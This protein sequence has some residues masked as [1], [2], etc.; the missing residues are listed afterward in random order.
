MAISESWLKPGKTTRLIEIPYYKLVRN[1]RDNKGADGVAFYVHFSLRYRVM[2]KSE[3][4]KAYILRPEFLFLEI[5][6]DNFKILCG[7][8]YNPPKCGYWSKVEEALF[9]CS[10]CQNLTLLFGDLNIN[11]DSTTTPRRML[12]E[13]LFV[14]N[15]EPLPFA[16]TFHRGNVHN[17]IDYICVSDV[18]KVS[19]FRQALYPSI[20]EHDVL[21]AE[22]AY[23]ISTS[24]PAPITRRDFRNFDKNSFI[25]DLNSIDWGH[26][27]SI[28]HVDEKVEFFTNSIR[29]LYD[30]HAPFR[31]Y[32]PKVRAT[33][34]K[35]PQLKHLVNERNKAWNRYRR[36]RK[37]DD[38]VKYKQLRNGVKTAT[39]NAISHYYKDKLLNTKCSSDM[40]KVIN[41]IGICSRD[42]DMS[43]LPADI[44]V[45][46]KHFVGDHGANSLL[47][48]RSTVRIAPDKRFYFQHVQIL[49][50][51]EA[52]SSAHSK[53]I[54]S[55]AWKKALVRP[56]PKR[57]H[58][59]ELDHVRPISIL[60]ASAKLLEA[61]ALKQMTSYILRNGLLDPHQSGF[62]KHHSGHT[63]L[64]NIVDDIRLGV[65]ND[66]VTLL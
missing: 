19:S 15:L 40:W 56:I 16:P 55:D 54:G 60:C 45:L 50:L 24:Q 35:T 58:P 4:P 31:S 62:R 33:P 44:N 2:A 25:N 12:S 61:V 42:S 53:A 26:L 1:D 9:N 22:L 38:H 10:S 66:E 14:C 48:S 21:F 28:H 29:K 5:S 13:S 51:L 39:R 32:T 18:E 3:Q 27:T 41:D 20:S 34:W 30:V 6:S 11:W 7:V 23:N 17:K 8:V 57:S 47:D 36:S 63:A 52:T 59:T 37:N 43:S 46:N 64:I 65:E 49:D